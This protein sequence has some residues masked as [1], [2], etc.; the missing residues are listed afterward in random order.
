M[1]DILQTI[2]QKIETVNNF[3]IKGIESISIAALLL[4]MFITLFDVIGAKLFLLPIFGALDIVMLAQIV[5]ISFAAAST[6]IAGRHV[7]V[8]LFLPYLPKSV[9]TMVIIFVHLMGLALCVL[10][11]MNLFRYGYSL[12][13]YGE[14]SPTAHIA[15]Y[16]FAYGSGVAFIPLCIELLLRTVKV[17][18]RL[19]SSQV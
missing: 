4:I 14:V 12:Q 19:S 8:E 15:M 2:V 18:F 3:V 1:R 7:H 10:I 13:E 5:A 11:A 6:L 9:R 16:P 17:L